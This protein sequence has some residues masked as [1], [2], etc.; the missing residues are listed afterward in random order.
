MSHLTYEE[1][2]SKALKIIL[3]LGVLTF[4]EVIIALYA[5]GHL[6]EGVSWHP[7]VLGGIMITMSLVKAYLIVYEFM[8][9]KYE[10]PGLVKSVLLPVLLLVWAIIAFFSEGADWNKRRTQIDNFNEEKVENKI[11]PQGFAP[12]VN[13]QMIERN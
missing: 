9:M 11:I 7:A 1:S 5:K 3:I 13:T 12:D 8:H 10:V 6:I 2:K 4:I